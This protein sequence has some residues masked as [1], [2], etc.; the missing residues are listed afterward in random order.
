MKLSCSNNWEVY[1]FY[2]DKNEITDLKLVRIKGEDYKV[3]ARPVSVRYTDHGHEGHGTSTHYFVKTKVFGLTKEFDLVDL[4]RD[5][6]VS[7]L[8][9]TLKNKV[10]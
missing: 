6:T 7:A 5:V 8:K 3:T 2:V 9:Y 10:V 1:T 4:M